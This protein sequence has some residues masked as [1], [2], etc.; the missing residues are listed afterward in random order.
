MFA[1]PAASWYPSNRHAVQSTCEHC[2]E[3]NRHERWCITC[4]ALVQYAYGAVID[5]T[6]LTL[7]DRLILHALG[8]SWEK[9]SC[10]QECGRQS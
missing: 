2:G 5:P 9:N 3:T 7:T 10:T 4:D 6:K 1:N 8:V